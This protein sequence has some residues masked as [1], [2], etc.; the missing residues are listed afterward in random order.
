MVDGASK[1]ARFFNVTI[2]SIRT[3]IMTVLI[4]SSIGAFRIFEPMFVLTK[5]GPADS[6][7]TISL[8]AY[9][10]AFANGEIGYANAVG[11]TLMAFI[12]VI[13]WILNKIA[14]EK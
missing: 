14:E 9:N 2:P 10:A 13:T 4:L 5:G 12:L 1:V 11:F 3:V 6:T 8:L 7:R